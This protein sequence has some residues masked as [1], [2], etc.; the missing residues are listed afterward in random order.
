MPITPYHRNIYSTCM[1]TWSVLILSGILCCCAII[2]LNLIR[3]QCESWHGIGMLML[4]HNTSLDFHCCLHCRDYCHEAWCWHE[5]QE[6]H[7]ISKNCNLPPFN[8]RLCSLKTLI[9]LWKLSG[10]RAK[11][12]WMLK[13]N[14]YC[15]GKKRENFSIRHA[16]LTLNELPDTGHWSIGGKSMKTNI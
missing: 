9:Q 3:D 11:N 6:N 15:M 10:N 7:K 16:L 4:C 2:V 13:K 1:G 5:S 8:R 12:A 14:S